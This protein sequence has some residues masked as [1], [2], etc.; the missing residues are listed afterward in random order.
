VLEGPQPAVENTFSRIQ[1]DPSHTQVIQV[2]AKPIAR[3]MFRARR[4]RSEADRCRGP[5]RVGA[6]LGANRN[7]YGFDGIARGVADGGL[8]ATLLVGFFALHVL[9]MLYHQFVRRWPQKG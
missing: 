5:G 2:E 1:L 7:A 4:D 6:P 3:R 8:T 9:A